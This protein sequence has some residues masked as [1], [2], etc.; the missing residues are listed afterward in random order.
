MDR[1]CTCRRFRAATELDGLSRGWGAATPIGNP[2]CLW[3]AK[4]HR[5]CGYRWPCHLGLCNS[6]CLSPPH[7]LPG[8]GQ[9]QAIAAAR[10][11]TLLQHMRAVRTQSRL[12]LAVCGSRQTK[13]LHPCYS[14]PQRLFPLLRRRLPAPGL[15]R[16]LDLPSLPSLPAFSPSVSVL[17]TSS[18]KIVHERSAQ[19]AVFHTVASLHHS[20]ASN[21]WL[22]RT[23]A[24]MSP[25]GILNVRTALRRP[26]QTAVTKVCGNNALNASIQVRHRS[27]ARVTEVI[28]TILVKK[29]GRIASSLFVSGPRERTNAVQAHRLPCRR[30]CRLAQNMPMRYLIRSCLC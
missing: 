29:T 27:H 6:Y 12:G 8:A 3:A 1:S 16:R 14:Y 28:A 18:V 25:H 7:L 11:V 30:K 13:Q 24:S 5:H 10:P 2:C 26:Q 4:R 21:T 9:E 15:S 20:D 22:Q 17:E 19:H 23:P